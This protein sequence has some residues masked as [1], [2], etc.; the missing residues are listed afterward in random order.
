[1]TTITTRAGKG[2]ALSF[3]EADA[4]LNNLNN[5]KIEADT[6]D[7]LTN[8]TLVVADNTVTTAASGN[9]VATELNAAL[10]ELDGQDTTVQGNLDTHIADTTTHGTTG[11]IVGTTD[12][13]SVSNKTITASDI[14]VGAGKTLDVSAGTLT[15]ADNQ[16]SGD[17]VDGG[18]I[19][20]FTSTGIDDN[21]TSTTLTIDG[22]QNVGVGASPS[23]RLDVS[24][25][26]SGGAIA[27]FLNA[28]GSG[29]T[30]S[31][32][33]GE[34]IIDSGE[35][36]FGLQFLG[37]TTSN[38]RI[39]FGDTVSDSAGQIE[40]DHTANSMKLRT[41][42]GT[43]ALTIDSSQQ[44]IVENRLGVNRTPSYQ[45]DV[46]ADTGTAIGRIYAAED[47]S[48]SDA[49][50]RLTTNSLS[51]DS[52][53]QFGDS[54]DVDAGYLRYRHSVNDLIIATNATPALTIDSSQH[55]NSLPTYN[56]TTASAA[57]MYV[58]SAGQFYRSTSAAKY[59]T[60]I[61]D[62]DIKLAEKL[63]DV[64]PVYYRSTCD[65]DNP[66][67]SH[68]GFIA[69]EVA[70]IDPRLV[71]YGYSET[72]LVETSP[73]IE[74]QEAELDEDGNIITEAIEAQEAEYQEVVDTE[75]DLVPEGVA[76]ERFVVPLMALVKKQQ[77]RIEA[78]ERRLDEA[79]L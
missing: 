57:N 1:M 22:S 2:S 39:M 31:S 20:N 24:K 61:E 72:K 5:D 63:L 50:L 76:Y 23:Y 69:E 16:I 74:A 26:A 46:Q 47:L 45:L 28:S 11:D 60:G 21:A 18:T 77:A 7:T 51:A 19:S 30:P 40:Y 36:N 53:V 67:W 12:I 8:K 6:T 15:L 38:Q 56:N 34:V 78:L 79:G 75:S 10:A 41:G 4:N 3:S 55:L 17:K 25:G 71:H 42:A 64:R 52:W 66:N 43:T 73:A 33:H 44:T 27:R 58:D 68:W 49:T 13:Q 29:G 14:T 59:K 65:S 62:M 48:S 70:E 54:D 37:S 9:L 35:A 32:T